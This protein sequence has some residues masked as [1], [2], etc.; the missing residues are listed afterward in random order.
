MWRT[1]ADRLGGSL[2][3]VALPDL[4]RAMGVT[5]LVTLQKKSVAT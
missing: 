4:G 3:R 1:I 2:A 5:K